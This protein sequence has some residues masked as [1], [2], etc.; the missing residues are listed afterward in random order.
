MLGRRKHPRYVLSETIVGNLQLRDEVSIERW[1]EQEV[2][3]LSPEP[4]KPEERLTLEV[5]GHSRHRVHVR[6]L[7]SRPSLTDG[8]VIRHRLRLA[9]EGQAG[10][11]THGG[12][13]EP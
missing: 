12:A 9:V 4:V 3:V 13:E 8:N 6:V 5:P 1:G 11:A 7:E 10:H 2:V